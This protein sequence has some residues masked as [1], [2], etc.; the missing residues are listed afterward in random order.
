MK[1]FC[2][3]GSGIAGSTI[4]NLLS[5]KYSVE[6]FDKARGPGGRASNRRYK[7]DLSFDHGLQ[8]ISPKSREFTKFILDLEKKKIL[9]KWQGNH[10]DF[11]FKKKDELSKYIGTKA[12]N[13]IPKYLIKNIKANFQSLVT[14]IKFNYKYWEI[15][16]NNKE[17]IDFKNLILTCPYPQITSLSSKYLPKQIIKSKTKMIP[18]VTVMLAY[19]YKL[20]KNINISSIKFNDDKL[21]W[22]ANENSKE[23]F[24][25]SE[26]LWTLQCTEK[27]SKKIIDLIKNNKNYYLKEISKE[28]ENLIGFKVND[29]K[30]KNI[31]GW[32]Y[33]YNFKNNK[34]SPYWSNKKKFGICADWISGP[35]AENAWINANKLFEQIKKNPPK[36]RV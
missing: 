23:R 13:A 16:I 3:V 1:D 10:L 32:R 18:N 12:N 28:F 29:L 19:K 5:K 26:I 4:A 22:A 15:T 6:I 14:N 36:R 25:S 9:K 24:K 11:T 17:K 21:A 2:I 20:K 34:L 33:A 35:K 30:F 8:Y 7:K 31:H 27:Y